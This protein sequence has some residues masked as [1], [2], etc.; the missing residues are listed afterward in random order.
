MCVAGTGISPQ[1]FVLINKANQAD[2]ISVDQATRADYNTYDL[3]LG[4]AM[5]ENTT[6]ALLARMAVWSCYYPY[7]N[8]STRE[9]TYYGPIA[10]KE[11]SWGAIKALFGD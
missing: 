9:F 8:Y 3:T 7:S 1:H 5:T 4:E 2:T 6:Y 10:T 11:T